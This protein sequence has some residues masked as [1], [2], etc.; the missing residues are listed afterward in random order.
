MLLFL[1]FGMSW[2]LHRMIVVF[3]LA[4]SLNYTDYTDMNTIDIADFHPSRHVTKSS[5][6][7]KG[8]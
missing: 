7:A 2:Y 3:V 5:Q 1:I 4:P 6:L 8:Y